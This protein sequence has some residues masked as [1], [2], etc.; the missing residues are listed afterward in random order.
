MRTAKYVTTWPGSSRPLA[1]RHAR[2]TGSWRVRSGRRKKTASRLSACR[3]LVVAPTELVDKL[4]HWD[5]A[6]ERG[7]GTAAIVGVDPTGEARQALVV[8]AVEP[9]ICPL[10]LKRPDEAL[11]LAVRLRSSRSRAQV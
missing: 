11:R 9:G 7:K 8:G 5:E 3:R 4:G 1:S 10:A 2:S 6:T